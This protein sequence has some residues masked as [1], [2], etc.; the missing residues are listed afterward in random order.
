MVGTTPSP[1]TQTTLLLGR[2]DLS[3]EQSQENT[4]LIWKP[5]G[6]NLPVGCTLSFC[7][8]S[9][10]I[11]PGALI[12]ILRDLLTEAPPSG[13]VGENPL[14]SDFVHQLLQFTRIN[15]IENC[16]VEDM[17]LTAAHLDGSVCFRNIDFIRTHVAARGNSIN[18]ETVKFN[19]CHIYLD[20]ESGTLDTITIDADST[21]AGKLGCS[22]ISKDCHIHGYAAD[23]DMRQ[24]SW[25]DPD[26]VADRTVGML[27]RLSNVDPALFSPSRRRTLSLSEFKDEC[28]RRNDTFT[29]PQIID[30]LK[31]PPTNGVIWGSAE[32]IDPALNNMGI[33]HTTKIGFQILVPVATGDFAQVQHIVEIAG[34]KPIGPNTIYRVQGSPP[35]N[36]QLQPE[37]RTPT[38]GMLMVEVLKRMLD[39]HPSR[40]KRSPIVKPK[41]HGFTLPSDIFTLSG[42]LD[43]PFGELWSDKSDSGIERVV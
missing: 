43:D 28:T 11:S 36:I 7:V 5:T 41:R 14:K 19:K 23:L 21:V 31:A 24:V 2:D 30:A 18:L 27:F 8:K 38:N 39:D 34:S 20:A 22:R 25:E 17:T 12:D 33:R 6:P 37:A 16:R 32:P 40:V 42:N 3:I 26:S 1:H 4:F 15:R 9:S 35:Q 10:E 29:L 13:A